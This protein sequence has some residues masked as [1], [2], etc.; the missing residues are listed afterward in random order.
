[1]DSERSPV[2]PVGGRIMPA[3]SFARYGGFQPAQ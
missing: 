2:L 3:F 1:M